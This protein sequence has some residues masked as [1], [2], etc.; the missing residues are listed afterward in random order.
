ML[1]KPIVQLE[2]TH[3]QYAELASA[4][5]LLIIAYENK[6]DGAT[7]RSWVDMVGSEDECEVANSS[8]SGKIYVVPE[9]L[10]LASYVLSKEMLLAPR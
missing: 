9:G 4:T 5:H 2:M 8:L 7:T 3:E 1:S 6:S 10:T